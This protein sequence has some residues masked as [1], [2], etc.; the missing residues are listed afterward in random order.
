M[1]W[2]V[3]MVSRPVIRRGHDF[4]DSKIRRFFNRSCRGAGGDY[5]PCKTRDARV[6]RPVPPGSVQVRGL[7]RR[8]RSATEQLLLRDIVI[9]V[10][11]GNRQHNPLPRQ[12]RGHHEQ[13][14]VAGQFAH[15]DIMMG[16]HSDVKPTRTTRLA[17]MAP[18][19]IRSFRIARRKLL[20]R[21]RW[22]PV[23]PRRRQPKPHSSED[24]PPSSTVRPRAAP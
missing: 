10:V 7:R 20:L 16:H 23:R 2:K 8:V 24:R 19:G 3:G 13:C 12:Q 11:V 1:E 14:R 5:R 6:R 22:R 17:R 4:G 15:P 9:S 21:G 18:A